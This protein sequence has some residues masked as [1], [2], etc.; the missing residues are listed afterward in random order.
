MAG[1]LIFLGIETEDPVAGAVINRGVLGTLGASD[2]N[3]FDIHLPTVPWTLSTEKRELPRTPLQL[4][5][6]GLTDPEDR[7]SVV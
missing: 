7:K 4:A 3:F 2:F 6:E 5:A 1:P